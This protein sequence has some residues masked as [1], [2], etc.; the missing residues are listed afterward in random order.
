M[1]VYR[2]AFLHAALRLPDAVRLSIK[3]CAALDQMVEIEEMV[4]LWLYQPHYRCHLHG[5]GS[6]CRG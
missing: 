2:A 1:R 3:W 5:P 4:L 6:F